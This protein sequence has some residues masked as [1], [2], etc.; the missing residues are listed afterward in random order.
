MYLRLL[1]NNSNKQWFKIHNTLYN[2][3][4]K[5]AKKYKFF[6]INGRKPLHKRETYTCSYLKSCCLLLTAVI[7]NPF[8]LSC[9]LSPSNVKWKLRNER[10]KELA[11]AQWK[12]ERTMIQDPIKYKRTKMFHLKMFHLILK[13]SQDKTQNAI[14]LMQAKGCCN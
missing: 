8:C 3:A 12:L 1:N 14:L 5:A 7:V 9:C 4:I 13:C 6:H 2:N 10:W 11:S